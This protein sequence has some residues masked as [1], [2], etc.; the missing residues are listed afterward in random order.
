MKKLDDMRKDVRKPLPREQKP[1]AREEVKMP[2][3]KQ[4]NPGI[5]AKDLSSALLGVASKFNIAMNVGGA[6]AKEVKKLRKGK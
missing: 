1:K 4:K 2:K 6:V 3:K 5:T